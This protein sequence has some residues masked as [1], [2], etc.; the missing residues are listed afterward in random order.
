[1]PFFLDD[2]GVSKTSPSGMNSI[3]FSSSNGGFQPAF[4]VLVS[5]TTFL[6]FCRL[7]LFCFAGFCSLGIFF[8]FFNFLVSPILRLML[9]FNGRIVSVGS[10]KIL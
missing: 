6:Y 1:M 5:A 4:F 2:F 10:S 9:K 7:F 3:L 8:F